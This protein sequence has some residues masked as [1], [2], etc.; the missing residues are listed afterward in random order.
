MEKNRSTTLRTILNGNAVRDTILTQDI[1]ATEA[2]AYFQIN[3]TKTVEEASKGALTVH[4]GRRVAT[5]SF[6]ATKDFGRSDSVCVT[7]CAVSA[8][9]ETA[10][11]IIVWIPFLGKIR[12]FSRLKAISIRCETVRDLCA[13]EPSNPIYI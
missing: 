9:C 11:G 3:V 7:L 12:T 6:K 5:T 1:K 13:V 8:C 2:N 10:F 4:S